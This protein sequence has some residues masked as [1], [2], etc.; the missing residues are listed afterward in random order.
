MTD[1]ANDPNPK[2]PRVRLIPDPNAS[3]TEKILGVTADREHPDPDRDQIA[4]KW[5]GLYEKLLRK[6]DE[7]IDQI[8][9]A[10]ADAGEIQPDPVQREP[11]D[12]ATPTYHRDE[13]LGA[14]TLEQE[15]LEEVNEAISRMKS[16]T[17]GTC[18]ATGRP[19]PME[20]LEAVPW[21]R[22]TIEAEQELEAQ[23]KAIKAS[24]GPLGTVR[25]RGTAPPGRWRRHE[26]SR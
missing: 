20:R 11:A 22:F 17:F 23:G 8:N 15:L 25:E 2:R 21:T 7:L 16:G 9:E 19:I 1:P 24:I 26:G 6:R 12:I 18:Q 5:H 4:P 13:M 10:A 3:E 14:L